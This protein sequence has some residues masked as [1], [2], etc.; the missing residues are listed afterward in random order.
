M[1]VL[2]WSRRRPHLINNI[3]W[4]LTTDWLN[5]FS[6]L[7]TVFWINH[8]WLKSF[9][10]LA[11]DFWNNHNWLKSFSKLAAVFWNNHNWLKP[12]L[13]L[14]AV[15]NILKP[16]QVLELHWGASGKWGQ[17][18]N[19]GNMLPHPRNNLAMYYLNF[20][21]P[22]YWVKTVDLAFYFQ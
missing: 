2:G 1:L 8:N 16:R 9:S 13:K 14:A 20:L 17:V 18:V 4:Q 5:P 12:F 22:M 19:R 3:H 10:K 6:K 21:T 7:A 11:A 15:F